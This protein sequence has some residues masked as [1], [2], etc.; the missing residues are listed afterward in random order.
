MTV[1]LTDPRGLPPAPVAGAPPP[2]GRRVK[3][4]A[5]VAAILA[6]VAFT[7]AALDHHFSSAGVSTTALTQPA[8]PGTTGQ[9]PSVPGGSA[10]SVTQPG[11]GSSGS[12]ASADLSIIASKVSP[13]VVD[14]TVSNDYTSSGGAATGIVLTSG[15]LVLTSNHV[16]H[17]ETDISATDV[18]S[19]QTYPATVVGYDKAHDIALIQ[20]QN[21]SGLTTADIGVSSSL[22]VGDVVV[23]VGNAGGQGGTPD[24]VGGTVVALDQ[25]IVASDQA[26]GTAEQLSGLIQT[27]AAIQS[28]DSGG[29]LVNAEG[30][31]IG[32]MAAASSGYSFDQSGSEGF[33]VPIDTAMQIVNQIKS[34]QGS[35]SVHIGQT[36]FLGVQL[37][38]SGQDAYGNGFGP[39]GDGGQAGGSGSG[40]TV[41]GVVSGSPAAEAGLTAGDVITAVDGTTVGSATELTEL[42]AAHHPGDKVTLGWTG[43][44]GAAHA[45]TVVLIAGPAG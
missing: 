19:G 14:I 29:P 3:R 22:A 16:I 44:S 36:A 12:S 2:R 6:A 30:Q 4:A 38:S 10:P 33:A 40:A 11:A 35:S 39:S 9:A 37:A 8:A 32:V 23:G 18:G 25:Q 42:I 45:K 41:A 43:T 13:A 1:H 24:V 31:V 21:A 17:G 7:G 20:L 34:G 15:G 26:N 28:G 27:D 5:A